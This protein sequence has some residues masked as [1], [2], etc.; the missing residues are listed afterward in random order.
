MDLD[1]GTVGE[2]ISKFECRLWLQ[3]FDIFAL[4]STEDGA[5]TEALRKTG[6]VDKLEPFWHE[7]ITQALGCPIRDITFNDI[8]KEVGRTLEIKYPETPAQADLFRIQN[9]QGRSANRHYAHITS[10]AQGANLKYLNPG[11]IKKN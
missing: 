5:P 8:L 10:L 6:L 1:P 9:A 11:K 3:K 2:E 4:A 7:R